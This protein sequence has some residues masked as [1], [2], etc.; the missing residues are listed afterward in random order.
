MGLVRI[1]G[2]AT[3]KHCISLVKERLTSFGLGFG[4]DI[5]ASTTD[6]GGEGDAN[7]FA[8]FPTALLYTR[9]TASSRSYKE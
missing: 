7:N 9:I 4:T 3:A 6:V 2:W 8:L 5:I 1:P